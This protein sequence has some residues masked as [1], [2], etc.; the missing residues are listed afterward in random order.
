MKCERS[1]KLIQT[2]PRRV[3]C[4]YNPSARSLIEVWH[5]RSIK[6]SQQVLSGDGCLALEK[7]PT[8][9]FISTQSPKI[10]AILRGNQR[11]PQSLI[12]RGTAS[13]CPIQN[14]LHIAAEKV[15]QLVTVNPW[16]SPFN[17]SQLAAKFIRLTFCPAQYLQCV[18]TFA[19]RNCKKSESG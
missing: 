17:C 13:N 8:S 14:L 19:F 18:Q 3:L 16:Q 11:S 9:L 10:I 15:F 5:Q 1:I 6:T 4:P 7:R 2:V 12:D